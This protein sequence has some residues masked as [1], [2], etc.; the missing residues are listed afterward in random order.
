M[1]RHLLA[2]GQHTALI[3]VLIALAVIIAIALAGGAPNS[4]DP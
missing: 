3:K 2:L 4:F 1:K